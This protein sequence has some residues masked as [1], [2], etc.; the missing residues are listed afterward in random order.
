MGPIAIAYSFEVVFEI[1]YMY[2]VKY[3]FTISKNQNKIE[4]TY[5]DSKTR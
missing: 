3:V 4:A 1:Q 2:L 5:S